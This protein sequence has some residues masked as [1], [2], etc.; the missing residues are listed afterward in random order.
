MNVSQPRKYLLL[1]E[2][3][4]LVPM[5]WKNNIF[6][7]YIMARPSAEN[8]DVVSDSEDKRTKLFELPE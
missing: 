2:K 6:F 3:G 4:K 1:P 8:F 5:V 7:L